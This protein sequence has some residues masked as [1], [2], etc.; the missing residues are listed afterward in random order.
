MGIFPDMEVSKQDAARQAFDPGIG[1]KAY[2]QL[3]TH[4]SHVH[5]HEGRA[6]IGKY[7]TQKRYHMAAKIGEKGQFPASGKPEV[8]RGRS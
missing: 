5:M 1:I 3:I 6:F 7:T 2:L 8:M 4:S